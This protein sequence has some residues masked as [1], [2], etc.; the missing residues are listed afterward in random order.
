MWAQRINVLNPVA[1]V[2]ASLKMVLVKG[3]SMADLLVHW[4]ALGVFAAVMGWV[5]V[6]TFRK[7]RA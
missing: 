4:V 5:S 1:H 3:S 6:A 7:L 2:I